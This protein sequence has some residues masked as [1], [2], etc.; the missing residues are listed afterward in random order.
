MVDVI[1]RCNKCR[2][3]IAIITAENVHELVENM[4]ILIKT[5]SNID[6]CFQCQEEEKEDEK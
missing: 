4:A 1:I 5:N 3:K 2:K 6:K